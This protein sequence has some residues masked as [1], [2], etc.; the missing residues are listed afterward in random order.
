MEFHQYVHFFWGSRLIFSPGAV[1]LCFAV[2]DVLFHTTDRFNQIWNRNVVTFNYPINYWTGRPTK[3]L[4]PKGIQANSLAPDSREI[5]SRRFFFSPYENV[6]S[7][8]AP[9]FADLPESCII[10]KHQCHFV[11]CSLLR[12]RNATRPIRGFGNWNNGWKWISQC[13][14]WCQ[15]W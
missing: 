8:G 9:T 6:A 13:R 7:W 11:R 4:K 12:E 2:S 1:T 14:H 10:W 15:Y 3:S 5:R